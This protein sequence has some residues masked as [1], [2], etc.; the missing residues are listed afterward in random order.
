MIE[1]LTNETRFPGITTIVTLS[2]ILYLATLINVY[3]DVNK[4]VFPL[5]KIVYDI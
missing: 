5:I 2:I 4:F 1:W 3:F